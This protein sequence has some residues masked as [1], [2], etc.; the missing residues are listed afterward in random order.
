[1]DNNILSSI[2]T[3]KGFNRSVTLLVILA[4]LGLMLER[5]IYYTLNDTGVIEAENPVEKIQR[6]APQQARLLGLPKAAEYQPAPQSPE[7]RFAHSVQDIK[8]KL[9]FMDVDYRKTSIDQLASE[10]SD[11]R[12]TLQSLDKDVRAEFATT[13]EHIRQHQLPP[14]IQQRQDDAVAHYEKNFSIMMDKLTAVENATT[15]EAKKARLQEAKDYLSRQQFKRSQQAFDPNNLPFN[16][17]KPNRN[18]T[19]RI[20]EKDFAAAGL[21]NNPQQKLAALGD[22]TFDALPGASDPAYLAETDEV[23]ITQAIRDQA[24]ALNHDPV[25]IY[26][27][28]L[29]NIEWLPTWGSIQDSDITLGSKKGNATDIASLLIALLRAS[30]IPARY[31]H[32]TVDVPEAKFRNWAGGFSSIEA[33]MDFASS[34]GIPITGILSGG[35]V[36][37]VRMEHVWVE[38]A[39]D[40]SPSRG[41]KN[42]AADSWLQMDGSYKQYQHLQGLDVAQIAGIDGAA[43]AQSFIDSGTVNEQEGWV[44]GFDPTVLQTAQQQAQTALE[45][46]IAN[47][48]TDPTVGDVIGGR[49]TIIQQHPVLPSSLQNRIV[50]TGSRYGTLPAAL[51]QTMTFSFGRDIQGYPINAI[52]LPWVQLNNHK[53]TL[54]FKPATP[55]DEQTLLSLLPDGEITDISQLP[56]SIPA[57]LIN[58][59]PELKV[60]GQL[61]KAGNIMTLGEELDFGFDTQLVGRGTVPKSYSLPA[62]SFLSVA[63]IGGSVSATVFADLQAKLADTQT[64]L[65]SAD[66]TIIDTLTREDLLGDMFHAGSLGY[67][68]QYIAFS[69]LAGL[70]NGAHHVLAGGA[71][72][73]GYEPNVDYFFGMPRTLT[74]GGV[75]L[76]KPIINIVGENDADFSNAKDFTMQIG[77]ISSMLE[78][79]TPELI[80]TDASDSIEGVSAVSAINK[81][82]QLGQRIYHITWQNQGGV[83]SS[84][85]HRPATMDEIYNAVLSGKEVITHADEIS[86][87][88][89]SGAGYVIFDPETGAGAYKIGGGS[90]GD[91]HDSSFLDSYQSDLISQL[92]ML[93]GLLQLL[94]NPITGTLAIA[95]LFI[96]MFHIFMITLITDLQLR[97]NGCPEGMSALLFSLSASLFALPKILKSG[98]S[99]SLIIGLSGWQGKNAIKSSSSACGGV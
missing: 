63:A 69:Y 76:N 31:V 34:G 30:Q 84:I 26:H 53:V 94:S 16:S 44:S 66:P 77:V 8:E 20:H 32:G 38:A 71:G 35:K 87:V 14:V 81:A 91:Y 60:N 83:L 28:V 43:L 89:W 6:M 99:R 73:F 79:D 17:V 62:G 90:N 9:A 52:T 7:T 21:F 41:A 70:Q 37:K 54:S 23:V 93:I 10:I 65:R 27:W 29:N 56:G 42:I 57:Y 13:A 11:I 92:L 85:H 74:Q 86:V 78:H 82:A 1:M 12:Q 55:E 46:H 50:V 67:Y 80:L 39:I 19:P 49:R 3:A 45:N 22:F 25:Q 5:V 58:V 2:R 48:M 64:K 72:S 15:P 59:V 95:L 36:T 18:N 33:A 97:E 24:Q 88:G 4:L 61:V 40:Y 96:Q 98:G 51:Q 68:A 75:A 47:N